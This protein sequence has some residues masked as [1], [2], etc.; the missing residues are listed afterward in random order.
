[1]LT[2][3]V[4]QAIARDCMVESMIRAELAGYRIVL[5]VHDEVVSEIPKGFGSQEEFDAL[6]AVCP[7]WAPG[8]PIAVEG[9]RGY[10]YKKG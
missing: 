2:E 4:V 9:W 7:R 10:R 6:M 8:L 1:M 5:T 3:N